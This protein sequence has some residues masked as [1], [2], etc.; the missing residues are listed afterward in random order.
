[1]K[2]Q[3]FSI[4]R[5]KNET[6]YIYL[7]NK[8][9]AMKNNKNRWIAF[10]VGLLTISCAETYMVIDKPVSQPPVR[11]I[12][13]KPRVALVLGGVAFHGIAHLGLIKVLEEAKTPIDLI[14]GTSAGSLIGALYADRPYC[15]SI[16][17]LVNSTRTKDVF[18]FSLLRS[19]CGFVSG[20]KLQN[21][22]DK[23][24][25]SR[26][27]EETTIPFIAVAT[28]LVRGKTIPLS[29]GPIAA[30]VNASCAIP[31]IFEPVKVYGM[32]LVDGGVLNNV[33]TDMARNY[34]P[35]MIIAVNVMAN[36]DT[37][38][39]I[40]DMLDIAYHSFSIA[41]RKL[42]EGKLEYA[43]VVVTPDLTGIPLMSDKYNLKMY[44]AGMKAGRDMLPL[45]LDVI[46]KRDIPLN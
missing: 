46:K 28:D 21:F 11:A 40:N 36:F 32:I 43:D 24:C 20:K 35:S 1:V 8:N 26:N 15:D 22:I 10:L 17:P 23:N 44:D 2:D 42:M 7:E 4:H 38:L 33:A 6:I 41:S 16:F 29:S 45:I 37:T 14:V 3:L 12:Q 13:M 31:L 39:L 25:R 30:S 9:H 34:E 19:D 18:D 5:I 27:I